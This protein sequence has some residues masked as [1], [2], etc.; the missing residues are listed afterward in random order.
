VYIVLL[1]SFTTAQIEKIKRHGS[2]NVETFKNVYKFLHDN[3]DYYCAL[4]CI[5]DVPLPC[6]EQIH[7][8]DGRDLVEEGTNSN[9]EQELC[10]KYWFPSVQD[11]NS[12]SGS[13]Q[14]CSEFSKALFIGE[15]PTLLYHPIKLI[16]HAKLSQLCPL[17]FPF[18]TGD[19]NIKRS[20]A[21]NE[22]ECLQ[23]YLKLS[24]P[25]FLEGQ[26]ILIIHHMYQR[27][28]S[29]LSGIAKCNVSHSGCTIADQLAAMT[30]QQVDD[31][32]TEM[33]KK[34]RKGRE[35]NSANTNDSME[36][37]GVSQ[38]VTE[39]LKCIKTSCV[40]IGYTNEAAAE[41]RN[42]MFALW[43]TFGP[44][45]ALFT[46]SP[47]DECSFKMQLFATMESTELSSLHKPVE[48]LTR[49]LG[50]RKSL[51]VKYPGSCA[52]EFDS[53]LQ[54]VVKHLLGW[55]NNNDSC[56]GIFG[57]INALATGVE[58]QG[59]TTL[60][61]HIVTW[62]QNYHNLQ[63]QLFSNNKEVREKAIEDMIFFWIKSY[64]AHSIFQKMK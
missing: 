2:Y 11:P 45:A 51:R 15:A 48:V 3:N 24:L 41:A 30:V 40:P 22:V 43:M 7:L 28:K 34:A 14:N 33:N 27:R 38:N 63:Q 18:G 21:V 25:Q 36:G 54:I 9:T 64:A 52:R 39:L 58:E 29:F 23:H 42:K 44:P 53:L 6:I 57:K 49:E 62:V 61:G 50:I 56:C 26:T 4:P 13:Y 37:D 55:D 16:T 60:H 5:N 35:S 32:I 17:A 10:W 1:G 46:V 12:I 31:V 47:C 8:N 59:R 19:V 20:P